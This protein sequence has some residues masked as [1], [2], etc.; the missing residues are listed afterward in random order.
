MPRN[1]KKYPTDY[2]RYE[3]ADYGSFGLPVKV[4][5]EPYERAQARKKQSKMKFID[6]L[7]GG[8]KAVDAYLKLQ[9]AANKKRQ[10]SMPQT[11]VPRIVPIRT[12]K[13]IK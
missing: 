11:D 10:Y 5:S 6:K 12:L 3:V 1:Y 13:K 2:P 7:P 8:S 4:E 9:S